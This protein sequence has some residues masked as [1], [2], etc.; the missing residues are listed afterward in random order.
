M[1]GWQDKILE[2]KWTGELTVAGQLKL[3]AWVK[4]E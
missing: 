1:G 2:V 4:S 3:E